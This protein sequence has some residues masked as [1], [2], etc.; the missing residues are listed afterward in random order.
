MG[1]GMGIKNINRFEIWLIN[2]DP[3]IGKEI[4]KTRPCIIISPN[5]M[6]SLHT[7]IIAP[8]TSKGFNFPMRIKIKFQNKN[9]L[10]LLDQI[11]AVDKQR[12]I[13]KIGNLTTEKSKEVSNLL[14]EIFSY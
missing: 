12:L 10:I 9:G 6:K 11:R 7:V 13:K 1:M 2:L 3:T 8:L 5:E 4:K 14:I